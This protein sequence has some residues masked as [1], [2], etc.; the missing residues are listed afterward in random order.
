MT[1]KMNHIISFFKELGF[2]LNEANSNDR[3]FY[4]NKWLNSVEQM[5][6]QGDE[7]HI[8]IRLIGKKHVEEEE[9]YNVFDKDSIL[10]KIKEWDSH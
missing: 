9:N 1:E 6:A 2:S 10:Q 8:T 4:M 7:D 3:H 5:D